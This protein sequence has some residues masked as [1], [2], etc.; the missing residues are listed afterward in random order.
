ML[1]SVASD[2]QNKM[3]LME[4]SFTNASP[5]IAKSITSVL[6]LENITTLRKV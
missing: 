4:L 5:R 2:C 3:N 1:K 6:A